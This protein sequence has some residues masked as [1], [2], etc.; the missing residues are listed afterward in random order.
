MT[1]AINF[2]PSDK[3]MSVMVY[4]HPYLDIGIAP[5]WLSG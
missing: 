2:G 4:M 5:V 1:D 3:N